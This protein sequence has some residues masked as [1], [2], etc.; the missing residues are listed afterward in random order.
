[1]IEIDFSD[2]GEFIIDDG[3][4]IVDGIVRLVEPETGFRALVVP[5]S[6]G[7]PI[8]AA[9]A[10]YTGVYS[11]LLCILSGFEPTTADVLASDLVPIGEIWAT[12]AGVTGD[13][14]IGIVLGGTV[15]EQRKSIQYSP[16]GFWHFDASD[17]SEARSNGIDGVLSNIAFIENDWGMEA[18]FNGSSSNITFSG[19][20]DLK[21]IFSQ[22]IV[23][24]IKPSTLGT[25]RSI[26][27]KCVGGE[28]SIVI[29]IDGT[30]TYY[31]GTS[32][33]SSTPYQGVSSVVAL[34]A[35]KEYRVALIRDLDSMKI[36]WYIDTT[37][38]NEVEA[39]FPYAV[40]T[41][42]PLIIGDGE[43]APFNGSIDELAIY[44]Y[45][46]SDIQTKTLIISKLFYED[47]EVF[48][49]Q[50]TVSSVRLFASN[51]WN[52]GNKIAE[53]GFLYRGSIGRD[54]IIRLP[55]I[56]EATLGFTNLTFSVDR[57]P[58]S[59]IIADNAAD[60][61]D[62]IL[63]SDT[64][65]ENIVV[66]INDSFD[67]DW[68]CSTMIGAA[69][70][71]NTSVNFYGHGLYRVGNVLQMSEG[72]YLTGTPRY[73]PT[74]GTF[75]M[76]VRKT[77]ISE[78]DK[79]TMSVDLGALH[80]NF[81]IDDSVDTMS[82]LGTSVV[83][84]NMPWL[85]NFVPVKVR[86]T[87]RYTM[88]WMYDTLV[89][90]GSGFIPGND[91]RAEVVACNGTAE[92]A[93]MY[94]GPLSIGEVDKYNPTVKYI[95][96][97]HILCSGAMYM[98]GSENME[99]VAHLYQL[100]D[101]IYIGNSIYA[102][103]SGITMQDS[104]ICGLRDAVTSTD[105][106][107]F[108]SKTEYGIYRYKGGY[109]SLYLSESRLLGIWR[110]KHTEGLLVQHN[111]E[112]SVKIHLFNRNRERELV[113]DH[114]ISFIGLPTENYSFDPSMDRRIAKKTCPWV[115]AT[116]MSIDGV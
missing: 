78:A 8:I 1:M 71:F 27:H 77:S 68:G 72:T 116:D 30:L 39:L 10:D 59:Y 47:V 81:I 42:L 106:L 63:N 79:L 55:H 23:F 114:D 76:S 60:H 44:D 43:E 97:G 15:M 92:L 65:R 2:S 32:G 40:A 105:V 35:G 82:I 5:A 11:P 56:P 88:V 113:F 111:G 58:L 91:V 6:A 48:R 25:R 12:A 107:Y 115:W 3:I 17:A 7:S 31:Y 66:Y 13:F 95:A 99:A 110:S 109:W 9:E 22:T 75:F 90:R 74:D 87:E 94:Y 93:S 29:E 54:N 80:L 46:L 67:A 69:I 28:M 41:E 51:T 36:R 62:L 50:M 96:A 85:T 103:A 100:A 104:H 21:I 4:E 34:E 16:V 14:F 38:T 98:A 86:V 101:N 57:Q 19:Y 112:Q 61:L 73:R 18:A 64:E 24:T 83:K 89:Y 53:Q 84:P 37:M 108:G 52:P 26:I 70:D 102:P 20:D 49:G 45:A 33:S